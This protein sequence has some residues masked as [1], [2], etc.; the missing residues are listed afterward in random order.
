[1]QTPALSE[2]KKT[3]LSLEPNE[4]TAICLRLAKY[5]KDNKELLS[6]LLFEAS[7]ESE[8][9]E[10]IKLE[11]DTLFDE[12]RYAGAYKYTKQIRKVLRNVLKHIKY[13]G[14]P[15]TESELLIHFCSRLKPSVT[16]NHP[17]TA[18]VNLYDRQLLR[19]EKALAK[20]HE[21]LR[22]DYQKDFDALKC[23]TED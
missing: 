1:M 10:S 18:L 15:G 20:L 5:K 23:L 11:T 21:D 16:G 14:N 9:I 4:L 2:I 7:R 6:Y 8:Y 13:S 12:M 17:L 3:L 19:I 22:Y